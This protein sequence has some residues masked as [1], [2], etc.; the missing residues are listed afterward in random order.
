MCSSALVSQSICLSVC[1]LVCLFFCYQYYAKTTQLIFTKFGRKVAHWPRNG[2]LNFD[3]NPYHI[4][5]EL[6]G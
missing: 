3:D 1:L 4:T 5:L 6:G 2:S